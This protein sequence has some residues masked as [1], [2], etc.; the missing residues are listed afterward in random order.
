LAGRGA[1]LHASRSC[2]KKGLKGPL[3]AALK[4][5][6]TPDDVQRLQQYML[7]LDDEPSGGGDGG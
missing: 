5:N 1:Y 6:L 7:A 2:W 4:V 3:E